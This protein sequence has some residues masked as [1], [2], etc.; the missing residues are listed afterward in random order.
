M[1]TFQD[2]K[3]ILDEQGRV[4]VWPARR[5]RQRRVLEYFASRF[6]YD[7]DYTEQQVNEIL[8]QYHIFGDWALLRR[9]L[10]SLRMLDREPDGTRYWRIRPAAEREG[11][12]ADG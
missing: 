9:E 3:N 2:L 10:F 4:T 6:A 8:N 12:T 5:D 11:N 7:T 1:D